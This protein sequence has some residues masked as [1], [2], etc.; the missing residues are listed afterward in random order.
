MMLEAI[1][2]LLFFPFVGAALIYVIVTV[3]QVILGMVD[4][5]LPDSK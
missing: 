3:G 5:F 4:D 2:G 1:F